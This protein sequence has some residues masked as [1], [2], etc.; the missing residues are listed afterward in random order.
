MPHNFP[1]LLVGLNLLISVS[2][3]KQAHN[4]ALKGYWGARWEEFPR[5]CR[6]MV[7]SM[8][9]AYRVQVVLFI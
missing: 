1:K 9:V 8:Q 2:A 3:A 5:H 7:F 6:M 4:E